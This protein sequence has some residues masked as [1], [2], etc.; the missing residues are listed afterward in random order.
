MLPVNFLAMVVVNDA[1]TTGSG[2]VYSISKLIVNIF[3]LPVNVVE[4][5][6]HKELFTGNLFFI[7]DV[8]GMIGWATIFVV[9]YRFSKKAAY[10][11]KKRQRT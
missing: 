3:L 9:L 7:G 4:S 11:Y 10:N 6:V 1:G 2:P 5:L 8:F